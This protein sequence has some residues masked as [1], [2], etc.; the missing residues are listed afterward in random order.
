M[1]DY[2]LGKIYKIVCNVTGLIYIG[3]TCQKYLTSRLAQHKLGYTKYLLDTTNK[4]LTSYEIIKNNDCNIILI[5]KYPCNDNIELRQ[6]ERYYFDLFDCVNKVKPYVSTTERIEINKD[7][8]SKNKVEKIKKQKI[9]TTNNKDEI[10]IYQ[11][12]YRTEN[13]EQLDLFNKQK[14]ICDCSGFYTP[15]H[16]SRHLKSN[17]HLK[18]VSNQI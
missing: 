15:K 3:S 16:K 12:K 9:Y 4:N 18:Y 17:L 7:Y 11:K 6:R 14:I 10:S 1:P 8:Y 2:Q 13:K 5:E